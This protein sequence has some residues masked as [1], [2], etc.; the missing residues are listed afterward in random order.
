M[1]NNLFNLVGGGGRMIIFLVT[2]PLLIKFMGL[3]RYGLW[4]LL[5]SI[6]NV[7]MLLDS[8]LTGTSMFFVSKSISD[9]PK[10][11]N[12][13]I[14]SLFSINGI[15]VFII[16]VIFLF[17]SPLISDVFF[18]KANF[19]INITNAIVL[20]GVYSSILISHNIFIGIIQ[21]YDNFK[22]VNIIKFGFLLLLNSGLV[23]LSYFDFDFF[24]LTQWLV[25]SCTLALLFY[26]ILALKYVK[27]KDYKWVFNKVSFKEVANFS[28]N[29][30]LGYAGNVLFNQMDKIIVGLIGT[31][32]MLGAYAA[33][34]SITTYINS[35]A[36]VGLQPLITQIAKLYPSFDNNKEKIYKHYGFSLEFNTALVF[37]L[38][39]VMMP[40]LDYILYVILDIEK[41]ELNL[42]L[43]FFIAIVVYSLN[44]LYVPGFYSLLAI[45]KS[46]IVGRIQLL[47]AIFAL[48]LV[49]LFGNKFGLLGA[50]LGNIGFLISY[51]FNF[52]MSDILK[53]NFLEWIKHINVYLGIYFVIL[54]LYVPNLDSFFLKATL[55]IVGISSLLLIF[56]KRN[57]KTVKQTFL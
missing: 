28:L 37:C 40:F 1:K 11:I 19:E 3:E 10:Q 34:I 29:T 35:L 38:G 24:V 18:L 56:Y 22:A 54:L 44:S 39:L 36:T 25:F 57:I 23:I 45:E 50:I 4:I 7:A 43:Y 26:I 30:W 6:G 12:T 42:P 48:F 55:S 49:Y 20:V 8:G 17:F 5:T 41:N 27:Y 9:E 16:V 14:T 33:I 53:S 32:Y 51:Y 46:K 21:S 47:S 15:I 31:P 52:K 13:V 2:I